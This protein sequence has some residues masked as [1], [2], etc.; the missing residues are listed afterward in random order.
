MKDIENQD[1]SE[2][3]PEIK[4]QKFDLGFG[5]FSTAETENDWRTRSYDGLESTEDIRRKLRSLRKHS[6]DGLES[7]EIYDEDGLKRAKALI[8]E[9][10]EVLSR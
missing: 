6:Y 5:F 10:K 3:K 7:T 1:R 4:E 2:E 9:F 8:E